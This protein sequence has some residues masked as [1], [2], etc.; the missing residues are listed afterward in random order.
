METAVTTGA[1]TDEAEVEAVLAQL[2]EQMR[3]V[4]EQMQAD[5]AEIARLKAESAELRAVT[6]SILARLHEAK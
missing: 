3:K 4:R 1:P 6:R 5:D 2:S